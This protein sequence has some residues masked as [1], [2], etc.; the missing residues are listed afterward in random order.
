MH[1]ANVFEKKLIHTDCSISPFPCSRSD[2][3]VLFS[4]DVFYL[5]VPDQTVPETILSMFEK[6]FKCVCV[7]IREVERKKEHGKKDGRGF[8]GIEQTRELLKTLT[9]NTCELTLYGH[10]GVSLYRG[11]SDMH[12]VLEPT[13]YC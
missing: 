10:V 13:H 5:L 11:C 2:P 12:T 9:D 4:Q 8:R 7:C 3:C 6:P 1:R